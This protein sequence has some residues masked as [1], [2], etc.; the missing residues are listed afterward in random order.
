VQ[1]RPQES[2]VNNGPSSSENGV[3]S[4]VSDVTRWRRPISSSLTGPTLSHPTLKDGKAYPVRSSV[5]PDVFD[6]FVDSL[7]TSKAI[8]VTPANAFCLSLL[9]KQFSFP[10]LE[11]ECATQ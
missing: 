7:R 5:P 1:S 2:P 6:T 3:A 10:D 11:S 9:A 4:I 8:S